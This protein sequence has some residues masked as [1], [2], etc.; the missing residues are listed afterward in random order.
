[1]G[2]MMSGSGPTVFALAKDLE[3]AESIAQAVRK[4]IPDQDLELFVTSVSSQ[5]VHLQP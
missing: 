2:V 4:Q 1:L 5:G 3:G